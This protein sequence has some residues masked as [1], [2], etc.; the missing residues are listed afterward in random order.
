MVST[1]VSSAGPIES[2][3]ILPPSSSSNWWTDGPTV[4]SHLLSVD[5]GPP[6]EATAFSE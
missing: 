5:W 1:P 3:G 2:A 4:N 6:G